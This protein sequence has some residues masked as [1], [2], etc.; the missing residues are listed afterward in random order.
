MFR[1]SILAAAAA[2][3]AIAP[4]TQADL[5][6]DSV[7]IQWFYPDTTTAVAPHFGPFTV[8][9]GSGDQ[10]VENAQDIL[11]NVEASSVHVFFDPAN[12]PIQWLDAAFNGPMFLDLDY[13]GAPGSVITAVSV[14]STVAGFSADRVTFGNDYV[15][16]N[17]A[18]LIHTGGQV[19]VELTFSVAEPPV[20][21]LMAFG[22]GLIGLLRSKKSAYRIR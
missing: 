17:F 12:G 15:A 9:A 4:A 1:A 21:G 22:L 13:L 19:D 3:L 14:L 20:F 18:S 2:M 7:E 6:G 8:E 10:Q 16:L 5:I 11:F